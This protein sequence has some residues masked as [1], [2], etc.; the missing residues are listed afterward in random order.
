MQ[1]QPTLVRVQDP[2][3]MEPI[4]NLRSKV[5]VEEQK[6]DP[7]LEFD[8]YEELAQHWATL[9]DGQVVACAR[10]RRTSHGYKIERMAVES[11][12]RQQGLGRALLQAVL[13]ELKPLAE[14]DRCPI[15]LHAQVQALPFY[16]KQGFVTDG[17]EFEEAGIA[18]YRCL[19]QGR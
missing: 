11:T 18:H 3:L 8:E 1:H 7:L 5:F 19:Y 12:H 2:A 10:S 6:V 14:R 9:I 16:T 4:F 13:E 17:D 15:Y